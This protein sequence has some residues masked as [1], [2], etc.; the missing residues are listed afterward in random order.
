MKEKATFVLLTQNLRTTCLGAIIGSHNKN[1]RMGRHTLLFSITVCVLV[2]NRD[3][4]G[5]KQS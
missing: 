5:S 2:Q 4:D 1:V 3:A